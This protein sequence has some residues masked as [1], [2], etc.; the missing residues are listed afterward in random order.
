VVLAKS[1]NGEGGST[2]GIEGLKNVFRYWARRL[3]AVGAEEV[4]TPN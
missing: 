3:A 4:E 1:G 2:G